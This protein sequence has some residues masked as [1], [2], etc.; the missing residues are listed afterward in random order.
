[1]QQ[2]AIAALL[3]LA[4]M[5]RGRSFTNALHTRFKALDIPVEFLNEPLAYYKSASSADILHYSKEATSP[6]GLSTVTQDQLLTVGGAVALAQDDTITANQFIAAI[7]RD[8]PTKDLPFVEAMPPNLVQ[9]F[10]G[11][12]MEA[13]EARLADLSENRRL[14]AAIT[15]VAIGDL[16]DKSVIH[17]PANID[18]LCRG[19][20]Y[21][22]ASDLSALGTTLRV[23]DRHRVA[24][25]RHELELTNDGAREARMRAGLLLGAESFICGSFMLRDSAHVQMDLR[26]MNT[27]TAENVWSRGSIASCTSSADVFDIEARLVRCVLA[28]VQERL[29]HVAGGNRRIEL[30]ALEH[31]IQSRR[32]KFAGSP[33]YIDILANAGEALSAEDRGDYVAAIAAWSSVLRDDPGS[34]LARSRRAALRDYER[35]TV[36]VWLQ[37]EV[38]APS[39]VRRVWR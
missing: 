4:V 18:N 37:I 23:V 17:T 3:A 10:Y 33:E 29:Q 30:D 27:R 35:H 1:M 6:G 20:T 38:S 34:L 2:V 28:S 24:A 22:I 8:D 26:L 31:A 19:L 32:D 9:R 5:V 25:L 13:C 39:R 12:R 16:E 14:T 36:S 15:S 7:L 21:A 11:A